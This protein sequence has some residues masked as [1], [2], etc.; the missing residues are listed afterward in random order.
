MKY[1]FFLAWL[2]VVLLSGCGGKVTIPAAPSGPLTPSTTKSTELQEALTNLA[3]AEEARKVAEEAKKKA[4]EE[5][6]K[7]AE[8]GKKKCETELNAM[9][10]AMAKPVE[11]AKR[12]VALQNEKNNLRAA[13]LAEPLEKELQR[14]L[15][16]RRR[17]F[18]HWKVEVTYQNMAIIRA[19]S[20]SPED[21]QKKTES[22]NKWLSSQDAIFTENLN[23]WERRQRD[24]IRI[25][26]DS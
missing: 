1:S 26:A 23:M 13:K 3:K 12:K 20:K 16:V 24:H 19:T 2:V 7:A 8:E 18:D 17:L 10:K 25:E 5:A 11:V 21:F 4:E 6:K 22:F 14:Q 9:V 15:K